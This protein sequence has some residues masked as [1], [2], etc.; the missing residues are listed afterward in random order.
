MI[1]ST[2]FI[3]SATDRQ[4]ERSFKA[5]SPGAAVSAFLGR[6]CAT[7]KLN[8]ESFCG[9]EFWF[10]ASV[11]VHPG[12]YRKNH[13]VKNIGIYVRAVTRSN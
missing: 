8:S 1:N 12:A 10:G 4:R 13:P 7:L 2:Q 11:T 5:N 3:V 9:R 6:R